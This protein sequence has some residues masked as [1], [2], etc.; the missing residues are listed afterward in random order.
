MSALSAT[1]RLQ[2]PSPDRY[3][4][5]EVASTFNSLAE[6]SSEQGRYAEAE[7]LYLRAL[8]IREQLLGPDHPDLASPLNGLANLHYM[9]GKYAEAESLYLRALHIRER[10]MG[11]E[12]TPQPEN[13]LLI[14]LADPS[15]TTMDVIELPLLSF[16]ERSLECLILHPNLVQKIIEECLKHC[17]KCV[18]EHLASSKAAF[19][20]DAARLF[21]NQEPTALL[22]NLTSAHWKNQEII[23]RTLH[24]NLLA[25]FESADVSGAFIAFEIALILLEANNKFTFTSDLA[26]DYFEEGHYDAIRQ[27]IIDIIEAQFINHSNTVTLPIPIL[28][29][30]KAQ[31]TLFNGR[32]MIK[33][34]EG[35]LTLRIANVTHR[36]MGG[37][38]Y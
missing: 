37:D 17:I 4:H 5:Q 32:V 36:P 22:V 3:A 15:R 14:E 27:L 35:E 2:R 25:L 12:M 29:G 20:K 26:W 19:G 6:L 13:H 16:A 11:R 33:G 1:A 24:K 23:A 9:Q 34:K 18:R 21:Q 7:P 30:K 31:V 10:Q 28:D 38:S 8:H